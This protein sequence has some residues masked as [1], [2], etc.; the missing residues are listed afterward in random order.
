MTPET[1]IFL[2][3]DVQERFRHVLHKFPAVICRSNRL[4]TAANELRMPTLVTEQYSKGLGH[5]VSEIDVSSLAAHGGGVFEKTTF[6]MLSPGVQVHLDGLGDQYTNFV[7]C[8]LEAHVCVQQT[9]LDLLEAGKS[10][11]LCVD[12]ISSGSQTDRAAGLRRAERAGAILTTTEAVMMEL[13]RTKDHPSFKAISNA[14]KDT[15][16]SPDLALEWV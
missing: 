11:H 3:C 10:V 13:I 16:L 5:T 15:K 7:V 2:L 1:C 6:S 8:G 12:G 9:A 4:L 14:L